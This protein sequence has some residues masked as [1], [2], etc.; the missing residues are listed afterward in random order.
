[1][2]S[3]RLV[4]IV[5]ISAAISYSCVHPFVMV[6]SHAMP[7]SDVTGHQLKADFGAIFLESFSIGM[8]P[9][10]LGFT[11][12]GGLVGYLYYKNMQSDESKTK[13]LNELQ[14]ALTEV[15]MLSGFLPICCVCKQ[16]RDDKGY[17]NHFETYISE[18]SEAKFSHTYCPDCRQK[19]FDEYQVEEQRD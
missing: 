14:A 19:A 10:S 13:L 15:K 6:I 8:L 12:L 5:S 16:I 9:W 4:K 2:V 7:A 11:I 3:G 17:W 18:Y 1:M